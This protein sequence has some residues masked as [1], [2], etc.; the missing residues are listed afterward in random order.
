MRLIDADAL[1]SDFKLF[2][3]IAKPQTDRQRGVIG[4]LESVIDTI[5]KAPTI[6]PDSLAKRGRWENGVCTACGFDL[7]CLTDGENELEQWVWDEG[8]DYC[9][10]CGALMGD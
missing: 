9:P 3:S 2:V 5:N 8:L 4:G 7:R 10:S 6:S 1:I